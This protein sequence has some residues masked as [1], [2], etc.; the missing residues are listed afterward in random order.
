MESLIFFLLP[1]SF[2]WE[3]AS[4]QASSCWRDRS[5]IRNQEFCD[6]EASLSLVPKIPSDN[7]SPILGSWRVGRPQGPILFNFLK[8]CIFSFDEYL[9]LL[10]LDGFPV[11]AVYVWVCTA[12]TGMQVCTLNSED[13]VC[14]T[15]VRGW[16]CPC[17]QVRGPGSV[18]T[19]NQPVLWV[20]LI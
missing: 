10:S 14:L 4:E 7:D 9:H 11:L 19:E 2:F 17:T 20:L 3:R 13:L 5:F 8:L 12:Q 18:L 15:A 1:N 6:V 16:L